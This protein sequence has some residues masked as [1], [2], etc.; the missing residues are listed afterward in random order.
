MTSLNSMGQSTRPFILPLFFIRKH[1]FGSSFVQ[2]QKSPFKAKKSQFS[3]SRF[4][5]RRSRIATAKASSLWT[6]GPSQHHQNGTSKQQST[7]M[8]GY[9]GRRATPWV[10]QQGDRCHIFHLC[11]GNN[12]ESIPIGKDSLK[13][14]IINIQ[15]WT[16]TVEWIKWSAIWFSLVGSFFCN[17]QQLNLILL[18]LNTFT[19]L[20]I[21]FST[22][23]YN[24]V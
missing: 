15:Q 11:L 23:H 8:K 12:G 6:P 22:L 19:H 7:K 1:W 10:L 16:G 14:Q 9:K 21:S 18:K 24:V 20:M 3:S 2:F 5:N 13:K 4:E 17:D